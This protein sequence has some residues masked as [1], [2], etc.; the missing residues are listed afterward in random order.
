MNLKDLFVK[1]CEENNYE[2]I[3]KLLP[4]MEQHQ[5]WDAESKVTSILGALNLTRVNRLADKLSG[6]EQKRIALAGL[7]FANPDLIIL[8]EPTNHL[9]LDM[10]EWLEQYLSGA[11][12]SILMVTHDRYFLENVCEHILEIDNEQLYSYDG[13]FTYYLTKKSER[14]SNEE[15]SIEKAKRLSIEEH[16]KNL[17]I[18]NKSKQV[19]KSKAEEENTRGKAIEAEERANSARYV[20]KAQGIKKVDVISAASKMDQSNMAQAFNMGLERVLPCGLPRHDWI[21][22]N[23]KLPIRFNQQLE[24]LAPSDLSFMALGLSVMISVQHS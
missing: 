20:E 15:T 2:N 21:A 22:G 3:E 24:C 12:Q 10:V 16:Q 23:L 4:L 19:L 8:D 14:I 9:D 1:H 17:E 18:I 6:G 13:N 7:I 5:L 11:N